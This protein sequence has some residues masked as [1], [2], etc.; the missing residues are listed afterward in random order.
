MQGA[1]GA[2]G[3]TGPSLAPHAP[4]APVAPNP[5]A[6][7]VL[8]RVGGMD[9]PSCAR[10][11][12]QSLER[13]A[14]VTS[15][16]V[17]VLQ[18]E[19]RVSIVPSAPPSRQVLAGAIVAAGFTVHQ[20]VAE[21][22]RP[23][24]PLIAAAISGVALAIGLALDWTVGRTSSSASEILAFAP[25]MLFGV[26]IVSGGWYV[27]PRGWRAIRT[28]ALDMH[29]LMTIAAVG[30]VL[31]GE[32]G[33][34]AAAMFLFAIARLL[35]EWAIGRARKAIAGLVE[36]AP[37]EATI[38]HSSG[39]QRVPSVTVP[40]GVRIRVKPGERVPLDGVI[41]AGTSALN[42]APITGES[43]PVDRGPGDL[44]YAGT[45]NLNGALEVRTTAP[46]SDTTLARILHRVEEAQAARAPLQSRVDRFAAIYTPAVVGLAALVA[47]MPPLIGLAG[48]GDSL[49]RAL[50]LL[51]IACPC[52][53]V[54]STPVT[55]V[56]GLAGAAR[57]GVL[58]KGGAELEAMAEIDTVALDKTGTLT[59]GKPAVVDVVATGPLDRRQLLGLAAA[60]ERHS[61]HPIGRAIVHTAEQER[62]EIPLAAGF[63]ALP[64]RGAIAQ[65]NGE[66]IRIGNRRL[67][68]ETGACRDDSH[69]LLARLES[70]GKTAVLVMRGREPVGVIAV[71]DRARSNAALAV[72]A[73]GAA[74]IGHTLMLTGDAAATGRAIGTTVGIGEVHAGLLPEEKLALV[75]RL[76]Q[77][78]RRV[79][80]VGDGINDAPALAAANIGIAMGAAGTHVALETADVA[81]MGDDLAL[82][83]PTFR[84]AR[85]TRAIIEQ[86]IAIAVGLKLLFLGLALAGQATLWMAVAADMGASLIV[87]ANGLRALHGAP[88][89]RVQ[90]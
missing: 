5:S 9:C 67:C 36:L 76:Q 30:G 64:G 26:A 68:D 37:A 34:S 58:I 28:G 61:E 53:L 29:A 81:L 12:V 16:D 66:E 80:V 46:A 8:L 51:V 49:V 62:V 21:Q 39:D 31:V 52:A 90:S 88:A 40:V 25:W 60:L 50:T 89:P 33:E 78:G 70:E 85:A 83:A 57:S 11:I 6:S 73:L 87:I 3:A 44:V 22:V 82:L 69:A 24:G 17:N 86:N 32:W 19:V 54:I 2:T 41:H 59:E 48:W 38:I 75:R 7:V 10:P 84:R 42:Q 55:I 4:H 20:A 18:G 15:V 71:A 35:E 74:G 43:M 72:A 47:L 56:S 79:A 45:I 65:V 77:Q 27:A 13:V 14:G 23:R 1:T 63:T